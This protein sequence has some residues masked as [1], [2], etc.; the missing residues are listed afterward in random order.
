MPGSCICIQVLFAIAG[1]PGISESLA[2]HDGSETLGESE[3]KPGG[4]YT[5]YEVASFKWPVFLEC[6]FSRLALQSFSGLY[7]ARNEPDC[8]A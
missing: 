8:A 6:Q 4:Q 3:K 2:C 7:F 5:K 1:H